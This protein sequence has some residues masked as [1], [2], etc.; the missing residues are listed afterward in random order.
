MTHIV[1]KAIPIGLLLLKGALQTITGKILIIELI[2]I[3]IVIDFWLTKN[4]TGRRMIGLRWSFDDDQYGV[5]R[6]KF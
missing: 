4:V 3:F 6:F 2:L 5:E 1:F